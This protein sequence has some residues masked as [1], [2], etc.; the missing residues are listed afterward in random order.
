MEVEEKR[1]VVWSRDL[2]QKLL[3]LWRSRRCL[4][5]PNS[6]VTKSERQEALSELAAEIG[7]T[8]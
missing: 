8:G 5:D 2:E 1:Y 6:F 4:F 7:V 3:K